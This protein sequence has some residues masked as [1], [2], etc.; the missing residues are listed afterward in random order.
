MSLAGLV[1]T[2]KNEKLFP[3]INFMEVAKL[4]IGV[5]KEDLRIKRT[6]KALSNAIF[7]LLERQSFIRLTINDICGEALVSRATFYA[8]FVDKYDLL[9][10][11]LMDLRQQYMGQDNTYE[12]I[13]TTVNQFAQKNSIVIR[14]VVDKANAETLKVLCKYLLS[15]VGMPVEKDKN[16]KISPKHIVLSN[17]YAGGL[18]YYL[19]WQIE[20]KFPEDVQMMNPYFYDISKH[21]LKWEPDQDR[22]KNPN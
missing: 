2:I 8:H 20:N 9:E 19:N 11:W 17:F 5:A 7:T 15:I 3:H 16:A 13:E 4:P 18:I 21:I 12:Q 1:N 22:Y 14:N 10:Y 6:D